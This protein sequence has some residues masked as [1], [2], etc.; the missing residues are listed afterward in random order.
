MIRNILFDMG[1]IVTLQ[2]ADE[3]RRRFRALGI[4]TGSQ[5]CR[6]GHTGIFGALEA[7]EI[8][9]DE[10]CS[11]LAKMV[12][13]QHVS[14]EEAEHCWLGFKKAAPLDRLHTLLE[15]KKR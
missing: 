6:H 9:E 7:G 13:R 14:H 5:L 11:E 4:D 3:A 15:L 1:G 8:C 2:D 12:G 10:F